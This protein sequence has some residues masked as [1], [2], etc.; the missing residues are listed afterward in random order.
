MTSLEEAFKIIESN[1][2][3]APQP[4]FPLFP[5]FLHQ[6]SQQLR[7]SGWGVPGAILAQ[8]FFPGLF[9]TCFA[10]GRT[11]QKCQVVTGEERGKVVTHWELKIDHC[12]K[13]IRKSILLWATGRIPQIPGAVSCRDLGEFCRKLQ[14]L[15]KAVPQRKGTPRGIHIKY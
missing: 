1:P 12:P 11:W 9:Q 13:R 8:T 5:V 7:W 3:P 15:G 14:Q 4:Y 2:A 6:H 10:Q